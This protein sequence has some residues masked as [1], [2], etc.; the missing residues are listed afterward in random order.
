MLTNS[1]DTLQ[2]GYKLHWYIIESVLGRG[3]FGITYLA[4]DENLNQKVAIKE[5]LPSDFAS[6]DNNQTVHPTTGE[7]G[8]LYDWGLERF[9]KEA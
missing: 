6:R 4:L 2:P 9:L 3:G 5:Y 7:Q 1:G 8:Q